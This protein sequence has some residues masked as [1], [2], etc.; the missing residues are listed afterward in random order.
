MAAAKALNSFGT[1]LPRFIYPPY[2]TID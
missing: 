1:F 2:Q